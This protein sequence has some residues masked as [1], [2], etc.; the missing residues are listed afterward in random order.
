MY[1]PLSKTNMEREEWAKNLSTTEALA[2]YLLD[3]LFFA[4][5]VLFRFLFFDARI[6]IYPANV[7]KPLNVR[8]FRA[9]ICKQHRKNCQKYNF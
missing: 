9:V 4:H 7:V 3:F 1:C 8:I 5:S 2:L 6:M